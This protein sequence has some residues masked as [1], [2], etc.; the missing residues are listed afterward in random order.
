M[1]VPKFNEFMLPLLQYSAD[2]QE[3]TLQ[4]TR[5]H[6]AEYFD[7]TDNDL[8]ELVPSKREP[9][10]NNRVSWARTYLSKA[11]LLESTGRG[12][13]RITER[14]L[15]F[16][17]TNPT[18]INS[19]V[20]KQFEEFVEFQSITTRNKTGTQTE[21]DY[22]TTNSE[23]PEEILEST[24]HLLNSNLEEELIEIIMAQSPAFFERLVVE[25]IVAMGYGGSIEEAGQTV[26]KSGDGGV[27]GMIKEDVLGF[28]NIYIQ[29]KRYTPG[30]TIGSPIVRELVGALNPHGVKKGIL[31]TTS[32]FSRGAKDYAQSTTDPRIVLIDGQELARLMI[33]HDLGVSVQQRYEIKSVDRDYFD[34]ES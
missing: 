9:R 10:F 1:P 21:E 33:E 8:Q 13:Y 24:F 22:G 23:T 25:L 11:K 19:D 32:S 6:L 15:Q 30:N 27:D 20:L 14:G 4:S 5:Q 17:D 12:I 3:K 7:L 2:R 28:D 26:G 18:H 29:A 34:L 16:L 31:I